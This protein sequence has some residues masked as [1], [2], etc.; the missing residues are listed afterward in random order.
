MP[1]QT[2]GP[3]RIAA[4]TS[5]ALDRM[6]I[7]RDEVLCIC[8]DG[9]CAEV[10]DALALLGAAARCV[11]DADAALAIAEAQRIRVA[12]D[13]TGRSGA[14]VPHEFDL[15]I[16]EA[17]EIASTSEIALAGVYDKP[18][19]DAAP[20][21]SLPRWPAIHG[22]RLVASARALRPQ[23]AVLQ[24]AG[25]GFAP[26]DGSEHRA[27][28]DDGLDEEV[29][30]EIR[31][32]TGVPVTWTGVSLHPARIA[33]LL[34]TTLEFSDAVDRAELESLIVADVSHQRVDA[35]AD[36]ALEAA[37]SHSTTV[38]RVV[39]DPSDPRTAVI[40]SAQPAPGRARAREIARLALAVVAAGR[41][42]DG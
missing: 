37:R 31:E 41:R 17:A 14:D 1:N 3:V 21:L 35:D 4:T 32:L 11:P 30:Q 12:I 6:M 33:T 15:T 38:S 40:T 27:T 7:E 22:A 2:A 29:T 42:T 34:T 9:A 24:A 26:I 20:R 10:V 36:P 18:I 19:A 8:A 25:V 39:L 28:F 23:R 13:L 16:V 5:S